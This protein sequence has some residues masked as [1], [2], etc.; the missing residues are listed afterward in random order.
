MNLT[1]PRARVHSDRRR[2]PAGAAAAA[3]TAMT[4]S[5]PELRRAPGGVVVGLEA[6]ARVLGRPGGRGLRNLFATGK[7]ADVRVYRQVEAAGVRLTINHRSSPA[8]AR[9]SSAATEGQEEDLRPAYPPA[10]GQF[11]NRRC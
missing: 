7:F 6:G 11:A 5:A 2:L 9:W 10:V 1:G 8:S 3:V 4:W